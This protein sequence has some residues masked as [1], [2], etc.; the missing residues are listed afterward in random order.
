MQEVGF[1]AINFGFSF[2]RKGI[3][4][5]IQAKSQ[6]DLN[7]VVDIIIVTQ[8]QGFTLIQIHRIPFHLSHSFIPFL[9]RANFLNCLKINSEKSISKRLK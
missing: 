7:S 8:N 4:I 5:G 1:F 6:T 3:N 9:L 2:S